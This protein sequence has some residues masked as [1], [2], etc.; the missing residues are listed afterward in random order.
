M[1]TIRLQSS[2][3]ETCKVDLDVAKESVTI[4]TMLEDLGIEGDQNEEV[5]INY[6]NCPSNYSIN[7]TH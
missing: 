3:G 7:Y 6:A 1:A 5:V 2:D 4:K